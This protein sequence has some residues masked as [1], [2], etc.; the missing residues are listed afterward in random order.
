MMTMRLHGSTTLERNS[1]PPD[2]QAGFSTCTF[3]APK[4]VRTPRCA[5]AG[6]SRRARPTPRARS[7]T[8]WCASWTRPRARAESPRAGDAD[9]GP[10]GC[11]TTRCGLASDRAVTTCAFTVRKRSAPP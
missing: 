7:R 9:Q 1:T 2:I 4:I 11:N 3:C 6:T 10:A 5:P 8:P